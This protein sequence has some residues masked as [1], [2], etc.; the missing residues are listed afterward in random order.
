MA[1]L[2]AAAAQSSLCPNQITCDITSLIKSC[3]SSPWVHT[4]AD[5]L[6]LTG[7]VNLNALQPGSCVTIISAGSIHLDNLTLTASDIRIFAGLTYEQY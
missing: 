5:L 1:V 7:L 4:S 3:Q 6:V 2:W